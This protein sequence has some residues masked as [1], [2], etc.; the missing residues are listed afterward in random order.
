MNLGRLPQPLERA[1]QTFSGR[2][3][4]V[5]RDLV[6]S[7]RLQPGER[8][9][10]VE[11]ATALGISRGPLRE[12]IQRLRSE[13]LVE[14]VPNRGA[15]VRVLTSDELRELYEV[16]VALETHATRLA[17]K[18][19]DPVRLA[20]LRALVADTG[21]GPVGG[22]ARGRDFHHQ[23]VALAGNVALL[24]A[25]TEV[26]HQ[27]DLV[28]QRSEHDPARA[29]VALEEHDTIVDQLNRGRGEAAAKA[30]TKHL[31]GSLEYAV[32]LLDLDPSLPA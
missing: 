13:G 1:T 5:L 16:R 6:T 11:L 9:N 2:T 4:E 25:A 20:E 14:T 8:L 27:I 7:G 19:P 15:Y 29:Q 22:A 18:R 23:L 10:E 17:A 32:T 12:A 3:V 26:R 21:P 28:R 30:L 24:D 31:R